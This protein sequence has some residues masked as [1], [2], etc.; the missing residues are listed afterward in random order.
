M[1]S[2][3]AFKGFGFLLELFLKSTLILSMALSVTY[4]LR[5]QPAKLKHFFLSI[6]LI[7]LIFLPLVCRFI[8]VW[9][10]NLFPSARQ[11]Y[12]AGEYFYSP[13][14]FSSTG[15][16]Q[17]LPGEKIRL[18]KNTTPHILPHTGQNISL[19]RLD[20]GILSASLVVI[21]LAGITCL[22]LRI[23]SGL[24][25]V[26]K[27]TKNGILMKKY[28]WEY[29]LTI[30]C[31]Q[32]SLKRKVNL[33]KNHK[34]K[35]PMTYGILKPVVLMPPGSESWPLNQCSPILFHELF[36]I[37]RGDFLIKLLGWIACTIFWFNPLTWIVFKKLKIE[38]E[39]AK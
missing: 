8:P 25:G 30:F 14:N 36:H 2:L 19:L 10:T 15:E 23:L 16:H 6:S 22:L 37:K 9:N 35:T 34:V 13:Q 3:F 27:L 5:N 24:L 1:S 7:A 39:K 26:K 21:W 4:L 20:N 12:Q 28:P 33:I 32:N 18:A 11:N 17:I 31:S 38:Q 29:L